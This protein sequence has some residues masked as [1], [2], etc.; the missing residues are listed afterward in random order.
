MKSVVIGGGP[1]GCHWIVY[2]GRTGGYDADHGQEDD[3]YAA[4]LLGSCIGRPNATHVKP[5]AKPW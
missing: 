4:L 1:R 3:R 5:V 2:V